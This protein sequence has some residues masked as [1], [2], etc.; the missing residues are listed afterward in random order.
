MRKDTSFFRNVVPLL[1]CWGL[2]MLGASAQVP[3]TPWPAADAL[4][5]VTGRDTPAQ[6][7]NR[8][9]GIFYFLWMDDKGNEKCHWC[10][11]P[12]DLSKLLAALPPEERSDP[13]TSTC[14]LWS[15]G[16]ASYYWGEPLFGYY[17]MYDPWILRR[18]MQ[19]LI[20]AGVDFLIFDTTN[21][22]TFPDVYLPLCELLEE[23]KREGETV[24]KITFML[25]ASI[26]GTA[27]NLWD[28]LYGTG[29]YD[30]LL[31]HVD[32][33]PLMIADPA[34]VDIEEIS[35]NLTLRRAHWPY[36]MVNTQGAWHWIAAYPQPY[37]WTVSP[38]VPEEVN[39]SVAQLLRRC[40]T[41]E[42]A[43]VS[44]M[45]SGLARGRSYRCGGDG[46]MDN[47]TRYYSDALS[48]QGINFAQ[49][50][51][52]AYELDPPYV[53]ITG[54]NEWIAGRWPRQEEGRNVFIDQFS[55][56]YSRDIEPMR[57]GFLDNYYL[58]MI[59]GIRRYKGMPEVPA[60]GPKQ[61]MNPGDFAAW[62][63][64]TPELR[65]HLGE[66]IPRDFDGVAL[67]RYKNN[68][69]RND[70]ALVKAARDERAFYFYVRT[71][72]A[73]TP[74]RPD[75]LCL[76]LDT[77]G[78][79]TD[80][81][82]GGDY[83]IGRSYGEQTASCEHGGEGWRWDDAGTVSYWL[84]ANEIVWRVPYETIGL[85]ADAAFDKIAFKVLDNLEDPKGQVC[86]LSTGEEAANEE[87]V[88]PAALYTT[89]DAAPESRFFFRLREAAR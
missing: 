17:S 59:E 28:D 6:K 67:L 19:L 39:V 61:T 54:W 31:F 3:G 30:D 9:V 56:E 27:K 89:G 26:A 75:G 4:G 10:E 13:E 82:I 72:E 12:Y 77:D 70:I 42:E 51:E 34:Y 81:F 18:H 32:G 37:G 2:G 76:L 23:L 11:G 63:G 33:K 84:A 14:D 7:Q 83:L 36:E 50:W 41:L 47:D 55:P 35:E 69:G 46:P 74:E 48:G 40:D 44:N 21:A 5:R 62:S 25:N 68:S 78:D 64:V 65:D 22:L 52:R 49:Q 58:Q 20:D 45:S 80:G 43:C 88:T 16:L 71:A 87:G 86:V 15:K 57:G 1:F 8:Q 85:D 73:I 60:A 79:L 53:M 29:K 66:T 38:D 24:P